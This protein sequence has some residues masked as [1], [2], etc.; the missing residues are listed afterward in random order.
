MLLL[1]LQPRTWGQYILRPYYM[2]GAVSGARWVWRVRSLVL[3]SLNTS[4]AAHHSQA[5]NSRANVSRKKKML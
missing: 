1:L 2:P 3:M 5:S 4:L